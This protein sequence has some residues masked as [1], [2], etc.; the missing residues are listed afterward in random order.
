MAAAVLAEAIAAP[1][2][3]VVLPDATKAVD[4]LK[5]VRRWLW[6]YAGGPAD[7]KQTPPAVLARTMQLIPREYLCVDEKKVGAIA[8]SS[9]GTIK[10]PGIEIYFVD[11][12]VR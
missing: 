8:R 4:G 7:L 2:P 1:A 10:I 12:P 5:F 3:V 6:R 11:E 9:K